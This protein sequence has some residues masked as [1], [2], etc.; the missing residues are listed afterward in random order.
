MQLEL[1]DTD[2]KQLPLKIT[3]NCYKDITM[4]SIELRDSHKDLVD[5][6]FSHHDINST[7]DI[8]YEINANRIFSFF[9]IKTPDMKGIDKWLTDLMAAIT[10]IE[11]QKKQE[12]F[13]TDFII[14][15]TDKNTKFDNGNYKINFNNESALVYFKNK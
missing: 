3:V 15:R 11:T 9:G 7:G 2:I 1:F 14:K 8:T 10:M 13:V 4:L 12:D 5:C 6:I